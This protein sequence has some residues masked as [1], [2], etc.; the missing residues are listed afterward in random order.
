MYNNIIL[1][2]ALAVRCSLNNS[3]RVRG[4]KKVCVKTGFSR[5]VE[6]GFYEKK[7]FNFIAQL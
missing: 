1:P 5:A 2:E 3:K 7:N 4:R 6:T